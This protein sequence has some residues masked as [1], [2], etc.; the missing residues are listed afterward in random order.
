[1]W[2]FPYMAEST[3]RKSR[4]PYDPDESLTI[5]PSSEAWSETVHPMAVLA[6]VCFGRGVRSSHFALPRRD[7][8]NE[9]VG[10][11]QTPPK[12]G[13]SQTPPKAPAVSLLPCQVVKM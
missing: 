9:N 8:R 7:K 1:M 2:L 12:A 11:S 5:V 3:H 10:A 13:A 6:T 4:Q